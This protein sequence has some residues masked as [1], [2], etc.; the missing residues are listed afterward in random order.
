MTFEEWYER[1][2]ENL[3]VYSIQSICRLAW[4]GGFSEGRRHKNRP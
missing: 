1:N 3:T 2:K 4:S